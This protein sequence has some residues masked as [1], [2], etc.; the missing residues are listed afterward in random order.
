MKAKIKKEK[1]VYKKPSI[2]FEKIFETS[3]LACGKCSSGP[4]SQKACKGNPKTS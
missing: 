1:K 4:I 3:A 2:V